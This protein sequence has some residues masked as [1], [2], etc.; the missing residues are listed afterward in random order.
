[1]TS[2]DT[3]T[4]VRLPGSSEWVTVRG[5]VPFEG[6]WH[7]FVARDDGTLTEHKVSDSAAVEQLSED[8]GAE[9]AAVLAGLWT[10]WMRA[11]TQNACTGFFN[12]TVPV[13]AS[14]TGTLA[15]KRTISA[16]LQTSMGRATN[17]VTLVCNPSLP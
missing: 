15:G 10:Q 17:R 7:L 1:L 13:R 16:Q 6:G 12:V 8:G 3:G 9:S 2:F 14:A 4:R 5:A 11:A